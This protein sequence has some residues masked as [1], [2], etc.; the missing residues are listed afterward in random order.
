MKLA[1]PS[2]PELYKHRLLLFYLNSSVIGTAIFVYVL[3]WFDNEAF[4]SFENKAF[5]G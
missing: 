4:H 5:L 2:V 1:K 3:E